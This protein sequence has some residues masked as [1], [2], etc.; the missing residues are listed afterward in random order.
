MGLLVLGIMPGDEKGV[1]KFAEYVRKQHEVTEKIC[2]EKKDMANLSR[3]SFLA[4]AGLTM[5]SFLGDCRSLPAD[6]RKEQGES[7]DMPK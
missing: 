6:T 3:R 4:G 2:K 1:C 5:L 7:G